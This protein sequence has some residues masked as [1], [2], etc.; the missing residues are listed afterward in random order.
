MRVLGPAYMGAVIED[1]RRRIVAWSYA[2]GGATDVDPAARH[3]AADR[4]ALF[5]YHAHARAP[6]PRP[7]CLRPQAPST[8]PLPP[9][10]LFRSDRRA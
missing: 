10:A 5:L 9:G 8:P 1:P 6:H 3:G 2:R 4:H 7:A